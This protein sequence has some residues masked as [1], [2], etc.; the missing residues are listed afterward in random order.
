MNSV[1][2][3]LVKLVHCMRDGEH[4]T[5]VKITRGVQSPWFPLRSVT[6][7]TSMGQSAIAGAETDDYHIFTAPSGWKIAGLYGYNYSNL[8]LRFGVIFAPS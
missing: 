6:F 5:S 3:I 1:W 2:M 4:I 7:N 8:V